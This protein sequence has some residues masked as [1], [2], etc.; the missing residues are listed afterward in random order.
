M[1]ARE[2]A[3]LTRAEMARLTEKDPA[4]ITH[5]ENGL[6]GASER[7][8]ALYAKVLKKRYRLIFE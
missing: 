2:A 6:S 8:V 3:G 7:S 5:L 4:F 1:E